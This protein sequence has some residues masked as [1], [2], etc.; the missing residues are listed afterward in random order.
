MDN[1]SIYK[2]YLFYLI[3]PQRNTR[4]YITYNIIYKPSPLSKSS[5]SSES[6][7]SSKSS[8]SSDHNKIDI[9]QYDDIFIFEY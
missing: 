2:K 1:N 9:L 7:E 4:N 3:S 6:S 8:E 5:K